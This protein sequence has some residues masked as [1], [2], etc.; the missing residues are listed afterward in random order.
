MAASG[1]VTL[2]GNVTGGLDGARSFGPITITTAAGIP[3]TLPVTL[4]IGANTVSI[5][6]GATLVMFVPPNGAN[7]IAN[8]AFGGTLTLKGVT[9]DTGV[10]ISNKNPT[11]VPFDSLNSSASFV[12]NSTAVGSA[13]VWFM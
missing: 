4:A 2:S 6:T 7:P 9:G 11:L 13:E 8:P 10:V 5:P 3:E 1:V 12:I